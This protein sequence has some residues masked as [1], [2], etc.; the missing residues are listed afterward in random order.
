MKPEKIKIVL[1][2]NETSPEMI[3]VEIEDENG[4]SLNI[5]KDYTDKGGYYC[6]EITKNDFK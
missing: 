3:F 6:I 4:Y 5:G 2:P 1:L